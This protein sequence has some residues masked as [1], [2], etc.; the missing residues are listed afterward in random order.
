MRFTGKSHA[1]KMIPFQVLLTVR[2][3]RGKELLIGIEFVA[4]KE[5]KTPFVPSKGVTSPIVSSAFEKGLL[6][7][8]GWPGTVDGVKSDHIAIGPPST[9]TESETIQNFEVLMETILEVS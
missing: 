2:Q 5:K 9:V 3:V 4:Y 1:K 6:V 7:M 8:P